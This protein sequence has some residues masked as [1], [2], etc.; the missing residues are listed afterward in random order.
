[1]L[2]PS[3]GVSGTAA[4]APTTPAVRGVPAWGDDGFTFGDLV[5]VINPLQHIPIVSW[6]Y[7]AITGDKIAPAAKV[8]G[9][10]LFGGP[11]GLAIS[12]VDAAI[13][14][15]TGRDAGGTVVAMLTGKDGRPPAPSVAPDGTAVAQHAPLPAPD[16]TPALTDAQMA[17]LLNGFGKP[18]AAPT[19]QGPPAPAWQQAATTLPQDQVAL[20]LR[21]VGLPETAAP[22]PVASTQVQIA[23][24][25][26]VRAPAA[27]AM[28]AVPAQ[29]VV[30]AELMAP[31]TP[32]P[33]T[34]AEERARRRALD[35]AVANGAELRRM[36][37]R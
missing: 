19:S 3:P 18:A 17:Q 36:F 29:P 6:A 9:G 24:A 14:H 25:G 34:D 10:A 15:N 1:M 33:A 27:T 20:L 11:V 31:A 28:P 30:V 16:A 35:D 32:A 4:P 22:A 5:D 26:T 13:L 37:A 23:P 2:G 12:T 7:R 8:F 21:S